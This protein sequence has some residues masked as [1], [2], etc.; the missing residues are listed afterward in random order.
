MGD[1]WQLPSVDDFQEILDHCVWVTDIKDGNPYY[2]VT[3]P[4]KNTMIIP[5]GNFGLW[6]SQ[7]ESAINAYCFVTDYDTRYKHMR[8]AIIGY[9]E[10]I[11]EMSIRPVSK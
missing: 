8:S 4:N 6:S 11:K 9:V 1:S 5:M 3:G 10:Q 7:P 2:I